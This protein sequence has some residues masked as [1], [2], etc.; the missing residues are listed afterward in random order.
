MLR[1]FW[2]RLPWLIFGLAGVSVGG[3]RQLVPAPARGE[4][5]PRLFL[6]GIVY[7][8]DAVGTQT[9]TL[10]V[11]GLSVG[12]SIREVVR[13][14]LLTGLLVG[15]SL[16]LAFVPV[17]MWRWGDAD[18]VAAVALALFTAC[19]IAALIAMSLPWLLHYGQRSCLRVGAS[20]H[21]H[22][23]PPVG[24][25]LFHHRC[26][27]ALSTSSGAWPQSA[28]PHSANAARP[29]A[30]HAEAEGSKRRSSCGRR[31]PHNSAPR[32]AQD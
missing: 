12:V 30:L 31:S 13:Q 4:R 20:S 27:P 29:C 23:R 1:R 8:A 9:E 7:M 21:G 3:H 26:Q 2:H 15:L 5:D 18:L 25:H 11:R 16:A 14:E 32:Q 10:I 17:A 28:A 24:T 6:P 22:P 19:S